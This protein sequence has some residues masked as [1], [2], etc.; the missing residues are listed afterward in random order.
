MTAFQLVTKLKERLP[1]KVPSTWLSEYFL[2]RCLE[3][4]KGGLAAGTVASY[5]DL[6][7]REGIQE[8]GFRNKLMGIHSYHIHNIFGYILTTIMIDIISALVLNICSMRVSYIIISL[9]G[10]AWE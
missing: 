3:R 9:A 6:W 10:T 7:G 4:K 1:P 8:V 5:R 2:A